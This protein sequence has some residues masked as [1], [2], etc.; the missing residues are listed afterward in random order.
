M[1][2]DTETCSE[3]LI[4]NYIQVIYGCVSLKCMAIR[5]GTEVKNTCA[6]REE[7]MV[8]LEWRTSCLYLLVT[9]LTTAIRNLTV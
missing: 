9:C 6:K 8:L 1:I 7:T 2:G 3:F 5:Y 4:R